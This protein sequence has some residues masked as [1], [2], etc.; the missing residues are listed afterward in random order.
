MLSSAPT[1]FHSENPGRA[2]RDEVR[3][4]FATGGL[5]G[6]NYA[7]GGV[8]AEVS[9][10]AD[11]YGKSRFR[12]T[13]LELAPITIGRDGLAA[14]AIVR[15]QTTTP[16]QATT[17]DE[18]AVSLGAG[19]AGPQASRAQPMPGTAMRPIGCTATSGASSWYES[20]TVR[21]CSTSTSFFR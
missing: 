20:T 15:R 9:S 7:K 5:T 19:D 21:G 16:R 12:T 18:L 8:Q 11:E 10:T 2:L 1:T 6:V 14:S 13:G 17:R 4:A 3:G